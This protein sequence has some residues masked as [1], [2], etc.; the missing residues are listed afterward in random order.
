MP[1]H[2][3]SRTRRQTRSFYDWAASRGKEIGP[4]L[5]QN[6]SGRRG[7]MLAWGHVL[8]CDGLDESKSVSLAC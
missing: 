8:P 2:C 5:T 4:V 6:V 1:V 7:T 3:I